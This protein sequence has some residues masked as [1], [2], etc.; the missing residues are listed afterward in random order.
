MK[1]ISVDTVFPRVEIQGV[2][3][4]EPLRKMLTDNADCEAVGCEVD[5]LL[6]C[7]AEPL[8][9]LA[10]AWVQFVAVG[11]QLAKAAYNDAVEACVEVLHT[12]IEAEDIDRKGVDFL[13]LVAGVLYDLAYIHNKLGDN[14]RAE[15]ELVKSQKI[16]DKLAKKDNPRFA[17]TLVEALNASTD[18]FQS[19]LKLMNLLA[20]YQVAADLYQNKVASGVSNAVDR[21][22]DSLKN[23]GDIHLK[24]GNYRDAVKYYTKAIR[25]HKRVSGTMGLRELRISLSMAKALLN[26]INRHAAGEQ[27]L[28]SLLPLAEKLDAKAEIEEIKNLQNNFNKTFD[29]MTFFKKLF[30]VALVMGAALTVNAQVVIGHRGSVWGVENTRAAFIN[31]VNN[32][33]EGLECDIHCTSDGLFVINHDNTFKRVGGSD[34]DISKMTAHEV[35]TMNLSQT[36]DKKFYEARPITLGEYLDICK[37]YDKIPVIEIKDYCWN[38]YSRNDNP[39]DF[40]YDGVPALMDLIRS[41]GLTDKVVIISFMAGVIDNIRKNY[42]D[43]QLQFLCG[44]EWKDYEKWC[45]KCHIDL[46]VHHSAV[47][48]E[49]VESFHKAG[50]RVNAWT[51]DDPAVFKRLQDLGVD[52]ITTNK[53]SK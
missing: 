28:A 4:I 6:S 13:A 10:K 22:V 33:Y 3:L 11:L 19:K 48:E 34:I 16:F 26:I 21:L 47:C 52:M 25:Y 53:L 24:I 50:L 5:K 37:E 7:E 20:H 27:L 49:M 31:G 2:E 9:V 1:P 51:V 8:P 41:K 18:I 15:K 23:Q 45:K 46:D 14:K 39:K 44:K 32:G 38:I 29:I 17:A 43:V 30:V 12:L 36:R 35:L 40:C 42:P